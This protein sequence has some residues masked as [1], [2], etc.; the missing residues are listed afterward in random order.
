MCSAVSVRGRVTTSSTAPASLSCDRCGDYSLQPAAE[1]EHGAP[2]IC[3]TCRALLSTRR[4]SALRGEQS[5]RRLSTT[6][7]LLALLAGAISLVG[8]GLLNDS[9]ALQILVPGAAV[10]ACAAVTGFGLARLRR[11]A[12]WSGVIIAVP[13]VLIFPLG[14][15][16]A[17]E[18]A[19]HLDTSPRPRVRGPPRA[20]T[21][22][23]G[24]DARGVFPLA[25]VRHRS[26]ADLHRRLPG[27]S[28]QRILSSASRLAKGT[29]GRGLAKGRQSVPSRRADVPV[30]RGT[31]IG[32]THP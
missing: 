14:T 4:Q 7:Y 22:D 26:A 8:V 28:D 30:P 15:I 20:R 1:G 17:G 31:G 12:V 21:P 16:I 6:F 9:G 13:L 19:L 29:N 11:W 32:F 27:P 2:R 25:T 23:A 5:L 10:A 3:P 18:A 24:A